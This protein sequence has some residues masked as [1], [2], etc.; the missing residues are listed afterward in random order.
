VH[1]GCAVRRGLVIL[2]GLCL[3]ACSRGGSPEV[4]RELPATITV[5]S[6]AFG[7]GSPIPARYTCSGADV[8]P[9]LAW[10]GV[11]R[12]AAELALVVDDPDAPRGTYVH[13]VLFHL[14]PTLDNLQENRL[15]PDA[16]QARNSGGKAGY[17]GP[18]PPGGPAHHYRFTLYALGD[19][20]DLPDRAELDQ[21]LGAIA[22][23]ATA[24]GRLT[25]TFAR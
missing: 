3:A 1:Y 7:D 12:D 6:P 20:L 16:R 18:C 25:G 10:S 15:P 22:K 17:A 5:R 4:G 19:R 9:A 23:A 2:L 14:D 21:A 13:W 11:P 8:A 24:Q